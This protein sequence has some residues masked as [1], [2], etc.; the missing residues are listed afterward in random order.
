MMMFK[1]AKGQ[2]V[3]VHIIMSTD[4]LII[5]SNNKKKKSEK[6]NSVASGDNTGIM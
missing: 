2:E 5:C 6:E 3:F 1:T 4:H